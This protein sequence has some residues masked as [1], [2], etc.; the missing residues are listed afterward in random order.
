MSTAAASMQ[1]KLQFRDVRNGPIGLICEQI[2]DS[3]RA[4]RFALQTAWRQLRQRYLGDTSD[5]VKC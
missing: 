1:W 4:F 5:R 3:E 2:Y